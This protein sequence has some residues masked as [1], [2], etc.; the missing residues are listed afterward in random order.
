MTSLCKHAVKEHLGLGSKKPTLLTRPHFILP[1]ELAAISDAML[2]NLD[3]KN[4]EIVLKVVEL[5][6]LR[7]TFAI[8]DVMRVIDAID[9]D[10]ISN[11]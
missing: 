5:A 2:E 7:S 11:R 8:V 6:D 1:E 10:T 3:A 4:T 9:F